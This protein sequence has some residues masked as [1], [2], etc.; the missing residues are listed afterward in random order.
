MQS[1]AWPAVPGK[2]YKILP[3]NLVANSLFQGTE[4]ITELPQSG[5][6]RAVST[7]FPQRLKY[8]THQVVTTLKQISD[9]PTY[10]ASLVNVP[11]WFIRN[12]EGT[13][14]TPNFFTSSFSIRLTSS[15][16]YLLISKITWKKIR[17]DVFYAMITYLMVLFYA[18]SYS[19]PQCAKML[20]KW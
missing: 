9:W 6:L 19:L 16:L 7:T 15:F 2:H 12:S 20:D 3:L 5:L 14:V 1:M 17:R 11:S 4:M 8:T 10:S 13:V 18:L